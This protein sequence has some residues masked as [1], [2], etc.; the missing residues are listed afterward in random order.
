MNSLFI[1]KVLL[2]KERVVIDLLKR[3]VIHSKTP[4][5]LFNK[6]AGFQACNFIKKCLKHNCFS[7]NILKF[8]ETPILKSICERLVLF[9]TYENS[10]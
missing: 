7:V 9:I 4:V 3:G 6:G 8:L 2:S 10:E 5:S 1:Q